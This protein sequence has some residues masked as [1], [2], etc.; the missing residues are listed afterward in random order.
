[1][2]LRTKRVLAVLWILIG[3]W[4]VAQT[5][6]AIE[7]F[8]EL[9]AQLQQTRKRADWFG[10]LST[11]RELAKFLN[12]SPE[13][14]LEL[15]RAEIHVSHLEDAFR[16][17]ERFVSMG[18]ATDLLEKSSE[19]APLR[20]EATFTDIQKAIKANSTSISL[21]S[22]AFVLPDSALL[23][24]DIDYDQKAKR[25]FITSVREWKIVSRDLNGAFHDF[26]IAADR[27]PM[28][29]IK[30]DSQRQVLWATEVALQG[31][32]FAPESDWGKS[33]V[34]CY[35]LKDG[36]LLRR[37]E[38]PRG[39][40]LGDMMLMKNGDLIVSDGEGGGV[41]RLARN[42][43]TLERIDNGQFISPQTPALHPDGKHVFVPD[44]VRGIGLLEIA[45]KRV[46][47]LSM[48]GR[49][50]L[51]GID[52]LY[53]DRG[54]LVAIQNGTSPERVIAFAT[55]PAFAKIT[56]E[57]IIERSTETLGDPTHGVTVGDDFY[58]IANSGWDVIDE[59]GSIKPGAK[60]SVPRVMRVQRQLF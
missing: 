38:A 16:E 3:A 35:A 57:K 15:A 19:F 14:T 30:A 42:G 52:G 37:V 58:Y 53:F 43:R 59:H 28:L 25:F 8:H 7:R 54:R 26:A 48:E 31:L 6:S 46:D 9:R 17:L 21:G 20:E 12:E 60:P 39:A 22:T 32:I 5:G 45:S 18:Q 34:L 44:Y 56:A 40:A 55:D 51:N 49:F 11:A 27:W 24:E 47:W 36:K 4:G 13:S 33:A 41:Y 50:A 2:A 29:A 1:M 10:S 23:A